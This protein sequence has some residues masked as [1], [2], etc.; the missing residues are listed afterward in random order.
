M[1]LKKNFFPQKRRGKQIISLQSSEISL[2]VFSINLI[3]TAVSLVLLSLPGNTRTAMT[4]HSLVHSR[5]NHQLL[6]SKK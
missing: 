6:A 5:S 1:G 3:R 2:V 4:L